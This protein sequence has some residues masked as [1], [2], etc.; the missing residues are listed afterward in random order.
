MLRV[1]AKTTGTRIDLKGVMGDEAAAAEGILFGRELMRLAEAAAR[2]D[3]TALPAARR[4]LLAVAGPEVLV[5]AAG[6]IANFQRMVRIADS[7]GIPVDNLGS[8]VSAEVREALPIER[9]ASAANSG[10]SHS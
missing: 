9:F 4:E 3:L 2:R 7:M 10:I 8:S 1:S 6:V 5:D